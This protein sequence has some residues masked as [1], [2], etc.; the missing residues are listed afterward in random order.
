MG[1]SLKS[2]QDLFSLPV[3]R[4]LQMAS[5]SADHLIEGFVKIMKRGLFTGMRQTY[6]LQRVFR[7]F[8]CRQ[9]VLKLFG[10]QPVV[11]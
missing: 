8:R 2:K 9:T 5:V 10:E 11:V 7:I 1:S 3:R 4:N 6:R